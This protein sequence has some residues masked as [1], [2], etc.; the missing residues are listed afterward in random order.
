MVFALH[1]QT[2]LFVL[3]IITTLFNWITKI[4][5]QGL[6]VLGLLIYGFIAAKKFY[7]RSKL[8]TLFRLIAVGVLHAFFSMIILTVFFLIVVKSYSI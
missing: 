2:F 1:L 7:K 8:A 5:I 6:A 4:D 3:L